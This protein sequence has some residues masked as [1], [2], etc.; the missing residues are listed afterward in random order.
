MG[1]YSRASWVLPLR[2]KSNAPAEFEVSMQNGTGSTIKAVVF[3]NAKLPSR[4]SDTTDERR[5]NAI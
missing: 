3:D 1:D 4:F 2:A 5:R